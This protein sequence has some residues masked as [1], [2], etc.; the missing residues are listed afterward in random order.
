MRYLVRGGLEI[1]SDHSAERM[2]NGNA[3]FE[4]ANSPVKATASTTQSSLFIRAMVLPIEFEG[5]PTIK[6]L[7]PED[8]DKPKVQTNHRFFDQRVTL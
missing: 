1:K 8:I 3:W 7:N 4:D 2:G 6:F 5:K